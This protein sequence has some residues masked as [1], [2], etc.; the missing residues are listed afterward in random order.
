[1]DIKDV[2][3]YFNDAKIFNV[4]NNKQLINKK[5]PGSIHETFE[6]ITNFLLKRGQLP[7]VLNFKD[8][9]EPKFIQGQKELKK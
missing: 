3:A 9:I 5:A 6:I 4:E 8:L 7:E 1:M 2:A